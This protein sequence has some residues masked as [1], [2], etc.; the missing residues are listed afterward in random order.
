MILAAAGGNVA[1]RPVLLSLGS[2]SRH[3]RGLVLRLLPFRLRVMDDEVSQCRGSF[4]KIAR[5]TVKG[6]VDFSVLGN[7]RL[8]RFFGGIDSCIHPLECVT[9]LT[10]RDWWSDLRCLWNMPRLE[11]LKIMGLTTNPSTLPIAGLKCLRYLRCE[12]MLAEGVLALARG[13]LELPSEC[14]LTVDN[15]MPISQTRD[16][17]FSGPWA[18]VVRDLADQM[19]SNVAYEEAYGPGGYRSD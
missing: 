11:R 15:L 1:P 4:P 12:E 19:A 8:L 10:L 17:E 14:I 7:I 6:D 9:S 18:Q 16:C 3:F 5:L 2:S 13:D